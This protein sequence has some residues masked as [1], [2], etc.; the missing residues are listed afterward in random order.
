MVPNI[1]WSHVLHQLVAF[2]L[3]PPWLLWG[4]Q[5][6]V[7]PR[8]GLHRFAA[9][10]AKHAQRLG[11]FGHRRLALEVKAWVWLVGCCGWSV[12]GLVG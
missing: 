3:A 2:T 1:P 4:P 10:G 8:L 9:R 5:G 12:G 6:T 7:Q 11:Y